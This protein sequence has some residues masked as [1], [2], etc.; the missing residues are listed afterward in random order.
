MSSGDALSPTSGCPPRPA[1]PEPSNL[2][3]AS[4]RLALEMTTSGDLDL[5]MGGEERRE[6]LSGLAIGD[7]RLTCAALTCLTGGILLGCE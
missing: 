4:S 6:G 2:R 5:L 3:L 7:H 1:W